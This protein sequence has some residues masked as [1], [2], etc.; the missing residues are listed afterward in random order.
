MTRMRL[1]ARRT[2]DGRVLQTEW[3]RGRSAAT[4]DGLGRR[5]EHAYVSCLPEPRPL[6]RALS[7]GDW[8]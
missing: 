1:V 2:F 6:G 7:I 8:S 3:K 4:I 5:T